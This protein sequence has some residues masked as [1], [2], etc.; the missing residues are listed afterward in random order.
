MA[1]TDGRPTRA[2]ILKR[3]IKV[4][5]G[6]I[7]VLRDLERDV[8]VVEVA[9][10]ERAGHFDRPGLRGVGND[11]LRIASRLNSYKRE[12]WSIEKEIRTRFN[13]YLGSRGFLPGS[14]KEVDSLKDALPDAMIKGDDRIWKFSYD[15]YIGTIS[16]Q[17]GR[18]PLTA[19]TSKEVWDVLENG[20]SRKIGS[21]VSRA[22]ALLPEL[23]SMKDRLRGYMGAVDVEWSDVAVKER[24]TV[25][26]E[27]PVK[28]V[29]LVKRP[30]PLKK[31]VKRPQKKAFLRP[32]R[33]VVGPGDEG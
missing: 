8:P 25:P 9:N 17:V 32:K 33:I 23:T 24:R 20:Q 21:L 6:S 27:R 22:N 2:T 29:L 19:P 31:E 18:D 16:G 26:I 13:H 30:V 7:R 10:M 28:K 1:G 15:Q 5:D 3:L 4:M 14:S 11:A 12:H